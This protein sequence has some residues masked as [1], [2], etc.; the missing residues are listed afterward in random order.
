[1]RTRRALLLVAGNPEQYTGGYLYDA[2]IAAGI[3]E[4]GWQ[5]EIIGL[6]GR[7]PEADQTARRAMDQT[8]AAVPDRSLVVIDG[9]ALGDLGEIV[10]RHRERLRL[11]ALVHHPLADEYGLDLSRAAAFR[12]RET[13]ALAQV[14]QV[15]VTSHFTARRLQDYGVAPSRIDVVLPGVE[16]AAPAAAQWPPGRLLCVATLIPR[17]GQAILV[18]ALAELA[19][20]DWHCDCIGA[21]DRDPAYVAAVQQAMVNH[22][23]TERIRLLGPMS[24]SALGAA[25]HDSDLFV[26]P[27]F[28][29]GYGMVVTEALA[30]GL[31]VVTTTGGALGDTLPADAGA[32][33]P[34]GDAAALAGVLRTLLTDHRHYDRARQAALV[35][36]NTL[37]DWRLASQRFARALDR[38]G[39][40]P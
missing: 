19:E 2:R 39:T 28:Y 7:F 34:P 1:V 36:R 20:L 33:V 9:L 30:R 26:L 23:L 37:D 16:P 18:E 10:A 12:E 4:F 21:L 8:L 14:E 6:A 38:S 22:G 31:P 32:A 11:V 17:K 25:Y 29:E 27:S 35:A 3:A 24:P 13:A 40:A 15:I 5:I